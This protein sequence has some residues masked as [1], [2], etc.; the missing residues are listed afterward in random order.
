MK[1]L[2][3]GDR[4]FRIFEDGMARYEITRLTPSAAW[5]MPCRKG[6]TKNQEE[7]FTLTAEDDGELTPVPYDHGYHC[8][9]WKLSTPDLEALFR[10]KL[11]V[12]GLTRIDWSGFSDEGLAAV[13]AAVQAE[14]DRALG[15]PPLL[16]PGDL[17]LNKAAAGTP[18]LWIWSEADGIACRD[19]LPTIVVVQS[20]ARL[21]AIA[22][23]EVTI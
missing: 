23:K 18:C 6:A 4:F 12:S 15:L 9:I 1:Q 8:V 11:I 2:A 3:V 21:R 10:R 16:S 14:K 22:G 5:G 7:R 17:V 20:A 19:D 13:A